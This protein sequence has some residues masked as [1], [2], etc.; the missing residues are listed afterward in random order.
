M[1][2]TKLLCGESMSIQEFLANALE[3]PQEIA[4]RDAIIA[5]RIGALNK[6]E[7]NDIGYY[8]A[9]YR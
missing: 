4:V 7:I 9:K 3:E 8:L 5:E 2:T 6:D 1:P